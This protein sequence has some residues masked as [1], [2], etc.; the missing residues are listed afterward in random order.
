MVG[1]AAFPQPWPE[2]MP[3][4]A[5]LQ[6]DLDAYRSAYYAA[7]PGRRRQLKAVR[8]LLSNLPSGATWV[9]LRAVAFDPCQPLKVGKSRGG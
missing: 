1:N 4:L 3:T 6:Q 5:R 2:P 7:R 9:G 8:L